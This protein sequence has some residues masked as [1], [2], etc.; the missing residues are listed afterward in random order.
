MATLVETC[1]LTSKVNLLLQDVGSGEPAPLGGVTK[2]VPVKMEQWGGKN[3]P[4]ELIAKFLDEKLRAGNKGTSEEELEGTL[5]KVLVLFRF[6]QLFLKFHLL[7]IKGKDVFEAF[8]KKDLA[9]RLLLGKSA[10]IDAE[11]SMISKLKTECG[12]QFTNKLEG[13]FKDIELSKEINESFKQ[14]SQARMKLPSGIE[15]SVHVLTTGYWPTYP[16]MDMQLPHELNV[17]QDI[18]KEFYLSKYSGRRL[19]WQNSLGHCVLKVEF[20]KGRKELAVSL[21]QT[22]VLMLF[23]DAQKLS[24]QDIKD[25]TGIEDKELRRT[26]QSLAC[27]KVRVLQKFP[28]GREV[29][30]IDSFVFNEDFSAPLYRIKVN[31]IQMKETVEEN[32]NT[33]ERVFQDRQYQVDAAIVRIMKTRK[34]LSHTLLITELF[35]QLKFP[36]KPA[37]LKKRIESLIDREYLER[38]KSNP[39]IYNYLA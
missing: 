33:T 27:G 12:S 35:Q 28:K 37:D 8:Y 38:D 25:S 32:T 14:S 20:P 1:E 21:F 17:Y 22:V 5:D 34:V 31:A 9:K 39:Q 6:I 16:P 15:L 29:G 2:L 23:N 19:M 18:F 7:G 24:F 26:L 13:M 10:S 30:D 11:K 3:R 36:I 4:A